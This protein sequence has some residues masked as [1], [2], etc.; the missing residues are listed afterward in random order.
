MKG[1]GWG[2][3]NG[4]WLLNAVLG[5]HRSVAPA[6][7]CLVWSGFTTEFVRSFKLATQV[8]GGVEFAVQF[9]QSAL[10]HPGSCYVE[11]LASCLQQRHAESYRNLGELGRAHLLSPDLKLACS[12]LGHQS[13]C[14]EN[15]R[16]EA[17]IGEG[18]DLC[19][20][21]AD[22]V[23]VSERLLDDV[24]GQ[25]DVVRCSGGYFGRVSSEQ[26]VYLDVIVDGASEGTFETSI[27]ASP[28]FE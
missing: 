26:G 10:L 15:K 28:A 17:A 4:R 19:G 6:S 11:A 22:S 12:V 8:C 27:I 25:R 21:S 24:G 5:I 13:T 16:D 7:A 18:S 3:Q 14:R 9:F 2:R 23:E 1:S 20:V